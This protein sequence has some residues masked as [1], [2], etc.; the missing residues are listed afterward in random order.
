[1]IL[2][3]YVYTYCLFSGIIRI[4]LYALAGYFITVISN[5]YF[6]EFV[7]VFPEIEPEGAERQ[8]YVTYA[9]SVGHKQSPG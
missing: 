6:L 3:S 4:Y 1:M 9:D 2:T 7:H 5:D 8:T